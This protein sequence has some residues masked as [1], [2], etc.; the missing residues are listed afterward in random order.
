MEIYYKS[1]E[2]IELIRES[3]LLVGKTLAMVASRI[4]PGITT[5]ELDKV[6]ED[7]IRSHGGIPTFLGYRNYKF[8]SCISVNSEIVHGLPSNRM[9]KD[10]DIVS[11]DIGVTKNGWVGDSAYTFAIGN[12]SDECKKLL[13]ITMEC[14]YTGIE[15]A[16]S[17]NRV[18]DISS[19]I[20]NLAQK[21]RYGVVRELVGHG[22][23]RH[24]HEKPD[25]PNF[26]KRG[27]GPVMQ[28]GLVI[29]IE[30]MINAGTKEVK[31][32]ADGWTI[33][34]ADNRPS[35]HF[36]HTVAIMEKGSAQ[37]LS[38]FDEIEKSLLANKE[39]FNVFAKQITVN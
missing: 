33:V 9:L 17:G 1:K 35:A 26:G 12:I 29:A 10:G 8:S 39:L 23:G 3:S 37:I 21:N 13:Q 15:Y 32:L 30:P 5:L 24:L 7:C 28:P 25:V 11:V 16:V 31:Q 36:E 4:R 38:S 34:T 20:Q 22:V 18:G 19:A 6:A 27:S 14:L 2:E